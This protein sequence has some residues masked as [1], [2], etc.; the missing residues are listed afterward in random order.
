MVKNCFVWTE[1]APKQQMKHIFNPKCIF[2]LKHKIKACDDVILQTKV[3][4]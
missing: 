2:V 3:I 4:K 1:I